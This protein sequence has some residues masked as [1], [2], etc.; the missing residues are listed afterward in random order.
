MVPLNSDQ[1]VYVIVRVEYHNGMIRTFSPLT[2]IT[3]NNNFISYMFKIVK[4]YIDLNIN[5]YDQ[6]DPKSIIINYKIS[7]LPL[8]S[9]SFN[10]IRQIIDNEGII[11]VP[12]V[13]NE[14][15]LDYDFLP[16]HMDLD[17]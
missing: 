7:N 3:N 5:H 1:V 12:P 4:G 15:V 9:D 11:D 8:S 17:L 6:Y 2:T 14:E 13:I 10:N 16:K